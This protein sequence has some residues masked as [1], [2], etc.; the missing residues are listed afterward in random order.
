MAKLYEFEKVG[1]QLWK[2]LENLREKFRR[3]Y[4]AVK[5]LSAITWKVQISMEQENRLAGQKNYHRNQEKNCSWSKK[6]QT[7][8]I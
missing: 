2:E 5:S 6:K 7:S 1:L 3:P 4:D 8:S